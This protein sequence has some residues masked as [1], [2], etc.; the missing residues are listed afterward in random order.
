MVLGGHKGQFPRCRALCIMRRRQC[1]ELLKYRGRRRS[2]PRGTTMLFPR[3]LGAAALLV[4]AAVALTPEAT[5][6]AGHPI[7]FA[8]SGSRVKQNGVN[9]D[10]FAPNGTLIHTFANFISSTGKP[11]RA[12]Q[13]RQSLSTTQASATVNITT[14]DFIQALNASVVVP[15]APSTFDSQIVFVS[16]GVVSLDPTTGEP[17]SILRSALQYGGSWAQGGPFYTYV[18]QLELP[19]PEPG[20]LQVSAIGGNATSQSIEPGQTLDP[21][22]VFDSELTEEEPGTYWYITGFANVGGD[23]SLEIGWETPPPM[24]IVELEEEGV[25]SASDYPTGSV[26]LQNIN[27]NMTVS[28]PPEISW[29][30]TVDPSADVQINVEQ[31]GSQ[32]AQIEFVFPDA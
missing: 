19:G 8:P 5:T 15:P 30:T 2:R 26:V 16:A 13:R 31:D 25:T 9:L 6:P 7:Y 18:I 1:W 21:Y 22:I 4:R 14:T 29:T 23:L 17:A 28:G 11:Q 32:N 3:A 27:L 20:Y 12:P 24:V 10:V